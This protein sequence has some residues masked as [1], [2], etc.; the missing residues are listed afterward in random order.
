M[1]NANGTAGVQ[2]FGGAP[3]GNLIGGAG[4]SLSGNV[5]AFNGS[6]PSDAGI[7]LLSG[8]GNWILSNSIH[9]NNG[10][11]ID[12]APAALERLTLPPG[13]PIP[14]GNYSDLI[15]GA[16]YLSEPPP[17]ETARSES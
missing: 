16:A 14:D 9:S 11:G 1:S 6:S 5:I 10:L 7:Q 3:T 13:R 17:Y 15:F 12:L 8:T 2:V 4:G